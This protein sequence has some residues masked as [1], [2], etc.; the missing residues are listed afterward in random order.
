MYAKVLLAYDGS[1]EGRLALREGAWMARLCS[2]DVFLLAVVNLST[3]ILVAEGAAPGAAEHQEESYEEV[4]QEGVRRLQNMGFS[5]EARLAVGEPAAQIAS[6]ATEI[7]ADLVVTGH[8]HRGALA[9]WWSGSV[10]ADLIDHLS[11][12]LL[13][14]RK[15]IDDAVFF[16]K[17]QTTRPE[18]LPR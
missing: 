3:G 7:N 4:L 18:T 14:S 13:V 15:E 9:R 1:I 8:R 10:A 11:C 16:R 5:P 6:V 12:S 2:A 17:M